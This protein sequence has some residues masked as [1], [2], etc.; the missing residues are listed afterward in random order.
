[1][2]TS[3]DSKQE[4]KIE[5]STSTAVA[6]Q[7]TIKPASIPS[8]DLRAALGIAPS[9]NKGAPLEPTSLVEGNTIFGSKRYNT[10][11]T[12]V[13]VASLQDSNAANRIGLKSS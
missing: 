5:A 11:V 1:M 2:T 9:L 12:N 3:F 8:I 7:Q 13:Q 10:A 6:P 4:K